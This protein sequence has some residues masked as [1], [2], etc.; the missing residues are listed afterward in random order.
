MISHLCVT[1]TAALCHKLTNFYPN[2]NFKIARAWTKEFLVLF[3]IWAIFG[4]NCGFYSKVRF[5]KNWAAKLPCGLGLRL[6]IVWI[7]LQNFPWKYRDDF[8]LFMSVDCNSRTTWVRKILTALK[9]DFLV[10]C[11]I[12]CAM[13]RPCYW[14][15]PCSIPHLKALICDD[16]LKCK[17]R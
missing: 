8:I 1:H 5:S 14:R 11:I 10:L 17:W 4:N 13:K 15:T 7:F 2:S 16:T 6:M 12:T 3:M 9:N